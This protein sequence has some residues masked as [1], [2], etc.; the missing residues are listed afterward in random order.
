[1]HQAIELIREAQ[2][3]ADLW[4]RQRI[5]DETALRRQLAIE[6]RD[7]Y[8]LFVLDLMGVNEGR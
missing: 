5:N 3:Q 8:I 7:T 2:A 4:S 1:M 6:R